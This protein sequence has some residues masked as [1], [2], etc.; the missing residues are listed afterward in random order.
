MPPSTHLP[1]H[2]STGT[3][4]ALF[5]DRDGVINIEKNYLYKIE[6]F[7]FVEGIFDLCRHYEQQGYL[8][9]VV[10]NQSGIARGYYGEEDFAT[11]TAWMKE[12]F[13]QEGVTITH[14]YHCPHHP[15]IS[16]PC[17]CRKPHPGMLN[18]AVQTYRIDAAASLLVGDAERDIEAAVTAG[19]AK[20][21]L[22][23][24]DGHKHEGTRATAVI[25]SLRELIC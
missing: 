6:D 25:T 24:H 22:Y 18:D 16:G 3:K 5:L 8:I 10:T 2:P 12:R 4:P 21:Y 17:Q 14:V 15:Q 11:L 13:E 9:I 23:V 19:V 20:R 1:I 7:E